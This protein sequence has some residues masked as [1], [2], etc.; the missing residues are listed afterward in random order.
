M[1]FL[2]LTYD[3]KTFNMGENIFN[4]LQAILDFYKINMEIKKKKNR[5][6]T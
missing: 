5:Q 1:Y 2:K 3:I 4:I 6:V